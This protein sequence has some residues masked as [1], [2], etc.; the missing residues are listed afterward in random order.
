M[1]TGN[2]QLSH[3]PFTAILSGAEPGAVIARDD[4]Q[5]FA[6]IANDGVV[7]VTQP[8]NSSATQVG[9]LQLATFINNGGL[10]RIGEN[11][12]LETASSGSPTP[13]TP[14]TNG[15]GVLLQTYV[16]T[17]N[18]NVAEELVS[19]IQTQRAYEMNTKAVRTADEM[20]ARL[21][22]L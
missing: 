16:E 21:G 5:R 11:L 17:A 7:S 22:Q 20:L 12:Y 6:L 1:G 10:Q 9:S 2:D 14:G 19:M 8:G 3:D 4:A 18:V 15:S 13:N